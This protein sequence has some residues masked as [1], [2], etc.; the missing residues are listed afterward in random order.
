MKTFQELVTIQAQLLEEL[1]A[2]EKWFDNSRAELCSLFTGSRFSEETRK[3]QKA[4]HDQE[5]EK[6]ER[7]Q[8]IEIALKILKDNLRVAYFKETMPTILEVLKKYEGKPYGEKTAAAINEELVQLA[9][10]KI[11]I[12]MEPDYSSDEMQIIAFTGSPAYR[13]GYNELKVLTNFDT[14]KQGTN[15]DQKR[16]MLGGKT[17]NR[18]IT[19]PMEVYRLYNC[20][21]Y[22]EDYEDRAKDIWEQFK[23]LREQ[24]KQFEA[25][26]D[27]LNKALPSGIDYLHHQAMRWYLT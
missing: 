24:Q 21:N 26:M 3:K 18:I 4:Y 22:V 10:I 7:K 27:D 1:K 2:I 20:K 9:R 25:G 8:V 19:Y 5:Q 15:K 14:T 11:S 23:A 12:R 13:F 6:S 16:P 17:G